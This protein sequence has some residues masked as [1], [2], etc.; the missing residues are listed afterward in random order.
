MLDLK[1]EENSNRL[2][3]AAADRRAEKDV[4]E[5][6]VRKGAKADLTKQRRAHEREAQNQRDLAGMIAA[7]EAVDSNAGV[8][9]APTFNMMRSAPELSRC[10]E[11]SLFLD[12]PMGR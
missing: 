11:A 6:D 8:R 5:D 1:V 7:K 2:V 4:V 9:R 3:R 12:K 10:L